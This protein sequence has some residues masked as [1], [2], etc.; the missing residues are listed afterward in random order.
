[1]DTDIFFPS[2]NNS[3]STPLYF[4]SAGRLG[5]RKGFED[6]I[7]CAQIVTRHH[8]NVQFWIA[9]DGPL[10]DK[11]EGLIKQLEL[12]AHVRL[13]GH[14]SSHKAMA[15][16]Y[17][18]AAGFIHPAHYEGLPTVLLE[19]MACGCPVVATAVSGALDVV[20]DGMNGLL[21][22]PRNPQG[23]AEAVERLLIEPSLGK[24]LGKAA[25]QA[26]EEH[27]SWDMITSRYIQQYECLVQGN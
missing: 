26:V 22:A 9:G 12:T 18:Q 1:M 14:I 20:Q 6:L 13:L 27:F 23:L 25:R 2:I 7:L 5:L 8:S 15:N 10:R 4:L 11:L 16:L 19:A 24:S 17:Q 21:V 3:E